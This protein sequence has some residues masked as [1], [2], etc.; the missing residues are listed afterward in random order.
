MCPLRRQTIRHNDRWQQARLTSQLHTGRL[1]EKPPEVGV[2]LSH[3]NDSSTSDWTVSSTAG[4][5]W[6]YL[7]TEQHA[8]TLTSYALVPEADL[9]SVSGHFFKVCTYHAVKDTSYYLLYKCKCN[10]SSK[11]LSKTNTYNHFLE[12]IELP[13]GSVVTYHYASAQITRH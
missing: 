6:H 11:G 8:A 3:A 1:T 9:R 7:C 12:V 13:C 10:T 5:L 2:L 4:L